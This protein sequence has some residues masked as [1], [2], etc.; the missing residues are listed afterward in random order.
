MALPSTFAAPCAQEFE[1]GAFWRA[2]GFGER[3]ASVLLLPALGPPLGLAAIVVTLLSRRSPFVA[4]QRVGQHGR[5]FWTW[6]LRTMWPRRPGRFRL[7][8]VERIVEEAGLVVKSADDPRVTSGF[9]RF[10]R[11][12]SIDELPQLIHVIRGEMALI[13][14]RP[15]TREELRTHYAA[16]APLVLS[17]K[18]GISGL[19]QVMGRSRLSYPARRRLDLMLVRKRTLRLYLF[20]AL[21]TLPEVLAG[22]NSW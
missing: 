18:P 12:Y 16:S 9:A 4:H 21:R 5:L 20:V 2:V 14:P 15:L 6:K 22:R 13:G 3:L 8:L 1:E 7:G 10:L 11:R 17:V 19:W